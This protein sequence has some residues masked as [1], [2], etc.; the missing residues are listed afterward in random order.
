LELHNLDLL[1]KH[2]FKK[3]VSFSMVC[4]WKG[5]TVTGA[6]PA[7]ELMK[8]VKQAHLDALAWKLGDGPVVPTSGEKAQ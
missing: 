8:H 6:M 5:C 2:L 3:H 7:A 4:G 1:K